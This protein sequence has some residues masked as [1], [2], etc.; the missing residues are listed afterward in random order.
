[1]K[2]KRL[3]LLGIGL[4]FTSQFL[5]S[6]HDLLEKDPT[7]SY[8]ETVAWSSE[9]SLD[10]YVTYLYKPL[11]GL[12]NFSSLSLTDG[13]TDLVKYGNGV[14]QTWSAHNKILL[15]Q[16]TI[17]S[18]NNPMSSWGLYTDIFR[19]NV[20]LR[21]AGIY[22]NKFSEDFLNIRIAEIR[23]I[24]AVNYARMIR[25]FG[26]VILRDETNGVDSEGQKD[27][28]RATE[29]ESWD[30]VLKDLEFAARHL[31]KEWD[32]KWDGRLTK[33]AAYAYMCR[34]A[35]FAKRW[36]VAITAAD[37]IKK[38][39]KY[40]LMDNYEDVFKVAGNK[41]IIFSIAYKIPDMPHYF[42][43]YFA[44]DGKQGIRR[45][46][47][48]SELV[49]SYDMA[50]GTPF[51]WS[52]SMANDPYVGREPRFYASIIYN[53][54]TWKEKKIYTYVDAENGFAAY[55]DNMNPGEKQTVTGYFIRKYL[56]EN[57]ADFDDKG[58]DQF[59]IEMRY[60]EVLLNLAEA[61][62]EQDY[63]KNQDDALEALNEVRERVNLPKRT[64][65]EAPDKDSFMKLLRKERICELAFEGFRYWDLRR[66]RLAGEVIDGKQAHGTKITKKDD[67][68]YT[69][70]QVSCD[71][72]I[73][74]FFPERYYL[75]PIP[76]DELQNNPLCENNAPW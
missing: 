4:M 3:Y 44:P 67:N 2:I 37:E 36:D 7:D 43:R 28:A 8:S 55:R 46:V 22:G 6:C 11:N 75:L 17:T 53:G 10:M 48:T 58:S 49:D 45:A 16:N 42:D 34:T 19:E 60:A 32:S 14:P 30:F 13:Y 25:I 35:L 51:S 76:V 20:F 64:T 70:E 38:L 68:T 73:N 21:D 56:Q 59:W 24:R 33:G 9:S 74:R 23:F 47:P 12:S 69:Y 26:G 63:S 27:K 65:E 1:M 5:T 54:A 31:P 57:N 41:E 61:L 72:N 62:A 52:G 66:W 15:Q 40:D 39:N 71:D 29:A 50:D 18:D